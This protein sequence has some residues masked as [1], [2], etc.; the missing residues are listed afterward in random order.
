MLALLVLVIAIALTITLP[1]LGLAAAGLSIVPYLRFPPRAEF[2]MHAPFVWGVFI[3]YCIPP[4]GVLALGWAALRGSQRGSTPTT[5]GP[6][7]WWGWVGL[8]L[9]GIAWL[10]AWVGDGVPSEWRRHVFTPMWSGY[11]LAVNGL[12]HQRHGRALLIHRPRLFVM[13]F[14][15]SAGFWWLFEYLNR[16]VGNWYYTGISANNDWDYFLQGTLPFSTVLPAVISTWTW[17]RQC[18]KLDAITLPAVSGHAALTWVALLAGMLG[19]G[20]IGIWPEEL[21]P[22]LWLAPLMLMLGLQ[23]V[24]IGETLLSPLQKGDWRPLLQPAFAV[25][26][27]GL[28][29]EFWNYGSLAKWHYSIPYVQRFHLFEMP[30][31]GYAGYLP[32]GV[33][34]AVVADLVSRIV[35]RRPLWPFDVRSNDSSVNNMS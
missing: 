30:L 15:V 27:C 9:I 20:G 3:A 24:L 4:L 26:V 16:F 11:I 22:L 18:P 8:G 14:P 25:L 35:E 21:Y 7:P 33:E 2:V 10:L 13:L 31:L 28:L 19:L 23:Q 6:F 1:L 17:L 34:C 5:P 29:W 12:V 32:F